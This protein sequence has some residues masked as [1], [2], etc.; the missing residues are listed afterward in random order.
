MR[1]RCLLFLKEKKL[2]CS[3]K[4]GTRRMPSSTA[5]PTAFALSLTHC[6]GRGWLCQRAGEGTSQKN[7]CA[8]LVQQGSAE[9]YPQIPIFVP[10]VSFFMFGCSWALTALLIQ[11]CQQQPF[12]LGQQSSRSLLKPGRAEAGTRNH[13][14]LTSLP[15]SVHYWTSY[16]A[17]HTEVPFPCLFVD[18]FPHC[19]EKDKGAEL[20][21]EV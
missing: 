4:S 8:H 5:W 12:S 11:D 15:P 2:Q 20:K 3:S 7:D 21:D 19:K 10:W 1:Y 13:M 14:H 17:D 9:M 16:L 18:G 6:T